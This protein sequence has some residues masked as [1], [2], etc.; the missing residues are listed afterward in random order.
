MAHD[1]V[2]PDKPSHTTGTPKVENRSEPLKDRMTRMAN[3]A[4]G[5]NVADRKPI[6]PKMP[7]L[8]PA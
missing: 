1:D 2:R 7:N 6:H 3:D 8:P 5:I 4:T